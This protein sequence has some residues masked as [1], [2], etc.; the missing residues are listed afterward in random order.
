VPLWIG[1]LLLKRASKKDLL[2][3][4]A[5]FGLTALAVVALA[6]LTLLPGCGGNAKKVPSGAVAIVGS[7]PVSQTQFDHWANVVFQSQQGA[8]TK[9]AK[10]KPVP[11]KPGTPQYKQLASQVLQFLVSS[12]W[13]VGEAA[14]RGI[15]ASPD[16]IKKSFEQ[17]KKQSFPTD[18]AYNKFLK[19]SGQTQDDIDFRVRSDVLAT[20]LRTEVT[21]KAADVS[22]SDIKDYY[23]ANEAQF[24]QPERRDLQVVVNKDQA[25]AKEALA[26]L[27]KGENFKKVV[28]ALSTDPATKQQDGKLLGV[29]K[30]QQEK[31]LDDAVFG[32]QKD[33]LVGPIKTQ[34]GFYVFKVTKVTPAS[35][36]SLDQSKEGIR[37]LLISQKQQQSLDSFTQDFREKWRGKTNCLKALAIPDCKN[38]QQPQTGLGTGGPPAKAGTG[39]PPALTPQQSSPAAPTFPGAPGGSLGGAVAPTAPAALSGAGTPPAL[40]GA[41]APTLPAG[42][43]VPQQVPQGQPQQGQPQQGQPQQGQSQ[44]G[45]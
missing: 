4:P 18:K 35:K 14:D 30:G 21:K 12:Q 44:Q 28:K 29:A 19:S 43:G 38:G 8:T 6:S 39:T 26:R 11:P 5:R 16:E 15:T 2:R 36:Q 32:A 40:G 25:K 13:I 3:L 24:S 41:A 9:K 45:P 37:Q 10:T 34:Q 17:T 7:Q 1:G 42:A 23:D 20:K 22:N 33:Q 31:S 27:Q